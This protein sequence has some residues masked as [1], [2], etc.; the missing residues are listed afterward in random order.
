MLNQATFQRKES[1]GDIHRYHF[2]KG[3]KSFLVAWATRD[4]TE[5]VLEKAPRHVI[6][7]WGNDIRV[8]GRAIRLGP[9]P[10]FIQLD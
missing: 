10:V 7:A 8:D 4:G 1:D 2:S 9:G 5:M 3:E 6:D